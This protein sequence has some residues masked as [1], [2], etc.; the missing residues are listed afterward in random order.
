MY[1]SEK[2][3]HNLSRVITCI[4]AIHI[5][6]HY[7]KCTKNTIHNPSPWN[8]TA[9]MAKM[10]M[11]A[12]PG[13]FSLL[14]MEVKRKYH[15]S[16]QFILLIPTLVC[17]SCLLRSIPGLLPWPNIFTLHR[18]V[19]EHINIQK[20]TKLIRSIL[21]YSFSGIEEVEQRQEISSMP[22]WGI[23]SLRQTTDFVVYGVTWCRW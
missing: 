18:R 6:H 1:W 14:T 5:F 2:Q 4:T 23:T 8:C 9:Q 12:L 19:D 11:G 13:S 22:T 15:T 3:H 21:V 17:Q 16:I 10:M 20:P 7:H